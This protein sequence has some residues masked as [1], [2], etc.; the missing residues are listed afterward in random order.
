MAGRSRRR[1]EVEAVL[2]SNSLVAS[3]VRYSGK[4]S[5]IYQPHQAWQKEAYRHI[6]ICGEARFAAMFMGHSMGRARLYA[7]DYI[8]GVLTELGPE[9]SA[10][11]AIK[12]LFNGDS[13]QNQMLTALG[14]H[15]TVG[16][17]CFLVGRKYRGDADRDRGIVVEGDGGE[18]DIWE[19][20]SPLEMQVK[21][22]QWTIV[23]GD[24]YANVDLTDE[25]VVI[26]IWRP[27]PARRIEAESPFKSLLPILAEIEWLTKHIFAQCSSR[28]AGAGI[29]FMP[30]EMTFPPPPP[31]DGKPVEYATKAD[32]LMLTL[33][34]GMLGSLDDPSLP[35]A[36]V[37]TVVI[38]P[39]EH[40]DKARL[41]HFWSELDAASLEMRAAAVHRFALGMDLPPEQVEGMSSNAG[42]GGGTSNGVSHWGAWQ[43]EESTIKLHI[44]P[45][46][47]LVCN[48]LTIG[49]LR[50]STDGMELV[51]ADTSGL[52]LRP[53]RSREA[54][55]LYDRGALNMK[56]LLRETG[57][58][59][60]DVPDAEEQRL[61]F[62]RK[63][64]SGSATPEQ[65]LAALSALGID[66][67]VPE[68]P[69]VTQPRES[70]PAPALGDPARPRDP[71]EMPSALLAACDALIYRGLERAGNRLRQ[72]VGKPVNCPSYETH[73]LVQANGSGKRV[74]EDAFPTA[75]MVLEG[76]GNPEK[77]VPV[78]EAYCS[79]LLAEQSPH[80]RDRLAT[81]LSTADLL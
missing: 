64:A 6:A 60:E 65:V 38:A 29:L 53:D 71:S 77:V 35:S 73:T 27:N 42:T 22:S 24:G 52:R 45:M 14:V 44:E 68:S 43:I 74:L 3:A 63:I 33:A 66:L 23:Y 67:N 55:Q 78:L 59:D 2:P 39:G 5:R 19:I 47:E 40:I 57:F 4:V 31:V 18:S 61:W 37:P 26:R 54:L 16:G 7:A 8:E 32:G 80:S 30:E 81:W 1:D 9:T 48:A 36:L 49:Y 28:L 12:G 11:A 13:G 51:K 56:A 34:D 21:G 58:S 10:G 25:D 20:V 76:I 62:L 79:T 72:T 17:E 69:V 15:L 46:L 50:P 70:R 41:M 75:P